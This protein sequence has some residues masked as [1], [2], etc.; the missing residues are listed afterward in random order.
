M[1][2]L[3]FTAIGAAG[4]ATSVPLMH[5]LGEKFSQEPS[6][7]MTSDIS[8][9]AL[10]LGGWVMV[11]VG[12]MKPPPGAVVQDSWKQRQN[13]V[14]SLGGVLVVGGV[15]MVRFKDKIPF[16]VGASAFVVGWAVLTAAIVH[17]DPDFED[18][19]TP[20]KTGRVIQSL[21]ASMVIVSSS[22][23]MTQ[24]TA[25]PVQILAIITFVLGWVDVVS[26]SALQ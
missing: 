17:S 22:A 2:K 12:L 21:V 11:M 26:M 14:T 6:K 10:F 20:E 19:A 23:I 8:T 24:K 18:M 5:L 1:S 3:D 7:K 16:P 13:I 4:I 9:M 15:A 25:R